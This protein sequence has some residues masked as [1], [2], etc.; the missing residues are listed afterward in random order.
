MAISPC[1][2][3]VKREVVAAIVAAIMEFLETEEVPRYRPYVPR[4]SRAWKALALREGV[5]QVRLGR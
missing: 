1:N 2:V 5:L 3:D 4:K